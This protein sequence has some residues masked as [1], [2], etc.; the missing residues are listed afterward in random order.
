MVWC[1]V[2][3]GG[4]TGGYSHGVL[5]SMTN[6][7]CHSS[8]RFIFVRRQS[9]SSVGTSF[10]YMGGHFRIW[11][12]I[13]IHGWLLRGGGGGSLPWPVSVFRCHIA[14]S[15]VAPGFPVSKESGGRGVFTHLLVIVAASDVAPQCH[16]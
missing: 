14:V 15:N 13:F 2:M 7:E 4:D 5:K 10:P 3:E 12:V 8:F 9:L 16:W 6:D 11:A 1:G